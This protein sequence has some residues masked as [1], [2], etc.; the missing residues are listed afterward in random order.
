MEH[1]RDR[2]DTPY[3]TSD[4]YLRRKKCNIFP[5]KVFDVGGTVEKPN[6]VRKVNLFVWTSLKTKI[7][8]NFTV[9]CT[10]DELSIVLKFNE[11]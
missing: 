5:P 7:D 2:D 8:K 1:Y 4:Q 11:C 6:R 9:W 3:P 10:E